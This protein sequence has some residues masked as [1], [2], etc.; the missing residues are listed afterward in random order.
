M[1]HEKIPKGAILKY[2]YSQMT[3]LPLG[4][5][6]PKSVETVVLQSVTILVLRICVVVDDSGKAIRPY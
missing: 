6:I 4:V 5:G 3:D 1:R 2:V